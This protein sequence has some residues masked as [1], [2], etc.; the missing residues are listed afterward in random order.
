L[1]AATETPADA[2]ARGL[3]HYKADAG[4]VNSLLAAESIPSWLRKQQQQKQPSPPSNLGKAVAGNPIDFVK[5]FTVMVDEG[6]GRG[7]H[8]GRPKHIMLRTQR[9]LVKG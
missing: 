1:A 4:K 8:C 6:R 7:V 5:L 2:S 9:P 3:Q